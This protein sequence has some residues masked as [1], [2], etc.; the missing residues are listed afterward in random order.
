MAGY[1]YDMAEGISYKIDIREKYGDRIKDL[2]D[3]KTN[4]ALQP[5]KIYKVA[6]NSYRASGGGGH[7]GAIGILTPNILWKSSFEM[8]TILSDYIQDKGGIETEVDNN[9]RV[10]Y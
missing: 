4:K 5:D 10:V 7:L 1:N 8:R 2:V 3:L 6:M 9:W